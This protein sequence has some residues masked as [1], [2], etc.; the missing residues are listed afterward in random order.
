MRLAL[1]EVYAKAGRHTEAIRLLE[2]LDFASLPPL[3]RFEGQIRLGK[4]WIYLGSREKAREITEIAINTYSESQARTERAELAYFEAYV[5]LSM[6]YLLNN[7]SSGLAFYQKALDCQCNSQLKVLNLGRVASKYLDRLAVRDLVL[8]ALGNPIYPILPEV[9]LEPFYGDLVVLCVK[10]GEK[11][12]PDYVNK[13]YNGVFRHFRGNFTF[14]CLTDNPQGLLSTI[15]IEEIDSSLP[16]WWSKVRLFERKRA[17]MSLYLDLDVVITG[18]ISALSTY[19]GSFLLVGSEDIACED[20]RNGYN[21]S[22][23]LWRSDHYKRIYSDFIENQPQILN[24]IDRFDHW[25]QLILPQTDLIQLQFP[26]LCRDFNT[27]CKLAIPEN[28]GV[29]IFPQS[30]KPLDYPADWVYEH[31]V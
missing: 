23:M 11:Y 21:S 1:A 9:D 5:T 31:W 14:I 27:S 26:G 10:V 16:L 30:P 17:E 2:A 28:C 19:P 7:Q 20:C 18:E 22:I 25:L 12:G 8:F 4:S 29:V 24:L 15:S 13:L 6:L 3:V